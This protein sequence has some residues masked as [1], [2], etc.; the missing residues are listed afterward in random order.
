MVDGDTLVVS[1][2]DVDTR[3]RLLNVDTPETKHPNEA[4]ECFGPEATAFLED[5]LPPGT[6]VGLDFDVE[7]EDRYGRTLAAVFLEDSTLVNAE[8]ARQGLG[9]AVIFEPNEKYFDEVKSAQDQAR[10]AGVGV[11]SDDAGC[12]L[13]A[14]VADAVAML[15]AA[16]EQPAAATSASAAATATAIVSALAAAKVLRAG[17]EAGESSV[18]W[19]ALG[20]AGTTSLAAQLSRSIDA[21]EG[22]LGSVKQEVSRLKVAEDKAAQEA[23]DAAKREANRLAAEA[24]ARAE[25]ERVAAAA[26]K[27]EAARRA[28]EAAA[29]EAERIRNV[30]A[31]APY[32]PPAPAPYVPPAPAPAPPAPAEQNL[33]PG[34]NGPRCYAPGGKTWKPC[35]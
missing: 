31:P 27:A 2:A 17:L 7:R 35:G 34:Y 9:S 22:K 16:S 23:A 24:A 3:V 30:P 29:A 8:I 19:A 25:A 1:I 21:A 4:V 12:T 28:A 33:Y 14:E 5:M 18:R 6:E 20:A 15:T 11:F 32:I 10:K 26:M 13:P